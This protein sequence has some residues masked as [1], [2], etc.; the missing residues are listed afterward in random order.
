MNEIAYIGQHAAEPSAAS[1]EHDT[2]EFTYC[3][4]GSGCITAAGLD[5]PYQ[6]GDVVV[7]PPHTP[8]GNRASEDFQNIHVSMSAPFAAFREPCVVHDDSH[9][10]LLGAFQAAFH[11]FHSSSRERAAFLSCYGDLIVHYLNARQTGPTHSKIVEDIEQAIIAHCSDCDFKL[12]AYFASL[13]FSDGYLR[14]LFQKDFGVTPLQYLTDRRLQMAAQAIR[15][16]D[17]SRQNIGDIAQQCG[18]RDPLYFSK[19]FKK[20]FGVAP[21]QFTG[22]QDEPP[23]T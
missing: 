17:H 8:H 13:P 14:K 23:A 16:A 15:C 12:D 5:L 9:R 1:H 10:F 18:F 20:K 2:W 7:I 3:I 22:V 6:V 11:H 21:S 19:I 4:A